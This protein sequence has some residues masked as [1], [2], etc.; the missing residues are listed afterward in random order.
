MISDVKS[1]FN[2]ITEGER[3]K[4]NEIGV[5]FG[6][7]CIWVPASIR[8]GR[9]VFS[10]ILSQIF[11]DINPF[12]PYPYKT[13]P[14]DAKNM[15]KEAFNAG[16]FIVINNSAYFVEFIEQLASHIKKSARNYN[17]FSLSKRNIKNIYNNFHL[18]NS[19]LVCIMKNLGYIR[20]NNKPNAYILENIK[21]YSSV[22]SN[23]KLVL[24]PFHILYK[25]IR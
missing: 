16:G 14:N 9:P 17:S 6:E 7:I 5:R 22:L 13:R 19:Q 24:S 1:L 20:K 11:Y 23:K 10:W 2:N 21:N 18:S 12:F 15:S 4:L 3:Q 8:Y 25:K